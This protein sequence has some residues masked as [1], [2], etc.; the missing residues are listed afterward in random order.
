MSV[1]HRMPRDLTSRERATLDRLLELAFPG[2][3]EARLQV[4]SARA[5]DACDCP[6]GSFDLIVDPSVPNAPFEKYP[7]VCGL[8]RYGTFTEADPHIDVMLWARAGRLIGVE[9]TYYGSLAWHGLPDPAELRTEPPEGWSD[10][11]PIESLASAN[12]RR[13][14]WRRK[15]A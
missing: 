15:R 8:T 5:V 1:P 9:A 6:C 10:T 4:V 3:R 13:T 14:R 12:V 7:E 11:P 2:A